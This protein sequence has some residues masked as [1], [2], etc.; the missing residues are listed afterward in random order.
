MPD[1][2]VHNAM[3]EKVLQGLDAEIAS[4]IDHDLFKVSVMGPDP[5]IYYRFFAPPFRRGINRRSSAMH[6]TRTQEFLTELVKMSRTDEV[7]SYAAG[8]LCHYSLDSTVHPF[9]N[10][11]AGHRHDMHMAIERRLDNEELQRQGKQR[12]D[13]MKLFTQD[14]DLTAAQTAL[15][16][17]Y[18]WDDSCFAAGYRHMKLYH[19]L[20]KDQHGLLAAVLSHIPGGLSAVPFDTKRAD[21]ID[22]SPFAALEKEAV[23]MGVR[24]VTA[25]YRFR[26]GEIGEDE[27]RAAIGNR[28]YAGGEARE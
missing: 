23:E 26:E 21:H 2:V 18:G 19:W 9:V 15:R 27:L 7:F 12:K 4:V 3:G 28:N 24:L 14:P 13:I 16:T 5:Y 25:A 22:L 20:A 8:F 17:V 11:M 1:I 10:T 6:R